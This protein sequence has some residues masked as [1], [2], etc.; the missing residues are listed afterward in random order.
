[1]G[2]LSAVGS[3]HSLY[4]CAIMAPLSM[5]NRI[6]VAYT[7]AP[8]SSHMMPIISY[9]SLEMH[10]MFD[11]LYQVS[12]NSGW[13]LI[14]QDPDRFHLNGSASLIYTKYYIKTYLESFV[15]PDPTNN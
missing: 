9:K 8:L 2:I 11:F 5:Q 3:C 14:M 15:T 6:S 4:T 7:M 10:K 1:M 13:F 12:M